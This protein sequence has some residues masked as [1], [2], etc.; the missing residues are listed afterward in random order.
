MPST[1]PDSVLEREFE[2]QQLRACV[3]S[4]GDGT[5]GVVLVTGEAGIGKSTL[6][7]TWLE[8]E[9]DRARV[10]LGWCD[11]FLTGR[12]LGP[13]HDVARRTGGDLAVAVGAADTGSVLDALLTLLDD[14]LRPVVLVLEDVHWADEATLD[15]VRYVGRR[16][17][18]L[19]ALLVLTFRDDEVGPD[20]KLTAVVAAL[21][22]A[23]SARITPRP[24]SSAAVAELI[25]GDRRDPDTVLA[26]T[27]GNPF[28]VTELLRLHEDVLPPTVA[29]AV[30]ARIGMLPRPT[31]EAVELLSV[32]PRPPGAALVE[33]LLDDPAVL[34]PAERRGLLVVDDDGR[35]R[36]RHELARQ[37]VDRSLPTSQRRAHHELVLTRLRE[38][39]T[40]DISAVLHHAAAIDDA[41]VIVDVGPGAATEAMRA[42]AHRQAVAIQ[43]QVLRHADLLGHAEHARL[44]EEHAWGLY[45]RHQ[46]RD[47]VRF[48]TEAVALRREL[49]DDADL[50]RA[51]CSLS[52]MQFIHN[53]PLAAREAAEEAVARAAQSG[54]QEVV[55]EAGIA[56]ASLLALLDDV[57]TAE[58]EALDLLPLTRR[59]G[60]QDLE[61]LALNYASIRPA[62]VGDG[63][64]A[65]ELLTEALRVAREGRHLEPAARAY[66]NIVSHMASLDSPDVWDWLDEAIEF[67]TEHDFPSH[68]YSLVAMRAQLLTG[69]G[70]WEEAERELL[71]LLESTIDPGVLEGMAI[72]ALARLRVRQGAPDAA[73]LVARTWELARSSRSDQYMVPAAAVWVEHAYL[74]GASAQVPEVLEVAARH[75]GDPWATHTWVAAELRAYLR[76]AG[77][78]VE[79][80]PSDSMPAPWAALLGGDW[81]SAAKLWEELGDPYEQAMA[82]VDSGEPERLLEALP[83][84]DDL[85]ARPAATLVRRRLRELGV[86]S[87]PRGPQPATRRNPGGLTPRQLDVLELVTDGRTNAEI[88]D[89]LVLSVRTVD[90]HVSAILAKLD[91]SSR[92]EAAAIAEG[93]LG[94]DGAT[95][96]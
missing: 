25:A 31:R 74:T 1:T 38:A 13:L 49:D 64:R 27:G 17:S 91:V 6:V 57:E 83:L 15:V 89:E 77:I 60:R 84:L 94:E 9:A 56:R 43:E 42:G 69:R 79:T 61:S 3:D 20:H 58:A 67:V 7:Q 63:D 95:S 41:Q 47:A 28:Y 12:T 35:V 23:V 19:G 76:R 45:A 66:T 5:G 21:G 81:Q 92:E 34:A 59:L 29:D 8:E 55:A 53:Q 73:D 86:R 44:L 37:A 54:D 40:P 22:A 33:Q 93:L 4:A 52:R 10:L 68:R 62:R 90:H 30:L 85:G 36:F 80:P 32:L 88:A 11:D 51:L 24:L 71:G 14:P 2:L 50:A 18:G 82:L 78:E 48:A 75:T 70:R 65:A 96:H 39:A 87:V 26:A 72:E 46:F 16:I